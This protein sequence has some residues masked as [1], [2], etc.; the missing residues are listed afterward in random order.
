[1]GRFRSTAAS[2]PAAT[3]M[4]S[5]AGATGRVN[6]I[7]CGLHYLVAGQNATGMFMFIDGVSVDGNT[8][9]TA[10]SYTLGPTV[11]IGR[12]GNGNPN[13]PW[14]GIIDEARISSVG[15]ST[16]WI[17]TEFN[18]QDAPGTFH[19][20]PGAEQTTS[21]FCATATP[22]AAARTAPP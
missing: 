9:I 18:N 22:T 21:S 5:G 4:P 20:A 7:D 14:S 11:E 19:S 3:A 6:I 1:M 13:Y 12:H 8:D 15:R 2:S 17:Q 10:I 16:A